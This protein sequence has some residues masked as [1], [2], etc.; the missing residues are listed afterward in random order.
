M[1]P[2]IIIQFY[3]CFLGRVEFDAYVLK[4]DLRTHGIVRF[5][6][7]SGSDI[8][9]LSCKDL[10][11]LGYPDSYLLSRPKYATTVTTADGK[12]VSL[13]YLDDVSIKFND[14]ELQGCRVYFALGTKMRSLFGNNILRYFKREIDY[15][16]GELKL[17]ERSAH[18]ILSANETPIQIYS[19]EG[20][21]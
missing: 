17:F 18:S 15:D 3:P 20:V 21:H 19:L 2:P 11:N 5:K 16:I 13:R 8:T 1:K 12:I 9:T 7:D 6:L 10:A 14:R 4:N